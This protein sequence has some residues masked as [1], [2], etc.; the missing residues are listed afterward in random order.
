MP[1]VSN[2]SPLLGLAAIQQLSLLKKNYAEILIPPAVL[3]ELKTSTDF[4]GSKIL[5]QALRAG[6]IRTEK[7][8]N[9]HLVQ[10]LS[11]ELDHGEA[12]AIALTLQLENA[13]ILMDEQDGRSKPKAMGLTL[14]GVLGILLR[15]KP[16]GEIASVKAAMVS[17]RK[18][19]GFF[20]SDDLFATIL[21]EAGEKL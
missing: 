18:E 21:T 12:E 5:R 2:T 16:N 1:V 13:T 17:L 3:S 6:W 11:L 8:R 10:A 19:I 15:T 14:V 4:S 20:I 9:Q 7:V